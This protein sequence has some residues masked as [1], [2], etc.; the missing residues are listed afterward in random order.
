MHFQLFFPCEGWHQVTMGYHDACTK[1]S[2][3]NTLL[4][5]NSIDFNTNFGYFVGTS[6]KHIYV[7]EILSILNAI[8]HLEDDDIQ[9]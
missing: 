8:L 1:S 2:S 3:I 5:G 6:I 4:L 7:F 9:I